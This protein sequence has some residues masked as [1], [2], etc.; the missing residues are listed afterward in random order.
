MSVRNYSLDVTTMTATMTMMD[1]N[2]TF[3]IFAGEFSEHFIEY[4]TI[5]SHSPEL[6]VNQ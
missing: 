1:W 6:Y 4:L 5:Y 3:R 2:G